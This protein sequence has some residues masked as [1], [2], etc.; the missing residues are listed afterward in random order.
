MYVAQRRKCPNVWSFFFSTLS[1]VPQG[2]DQKR[3][4]FCTNRFVLAP[5][6]AKNTYNKRLTLKSSVQWYH[7]AECDIILSLLSWLAGAYF[8]LCMH[9]LITSD[10]WLSMLSSLCI[11]TA[12]F[13]LRH[14]RHRL[15]LW[16]C[17]LWVPKIS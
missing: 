8:F 17:D 14:R 15:E 16:L 7:M 13:S 10:L 2:Y 1:M 6:S 4:L 3:K 9:L 5:S 12:S 11:V